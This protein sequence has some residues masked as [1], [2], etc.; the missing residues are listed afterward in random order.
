M[1]REWFEDKRCLDIGCNA[2]VV[3]FDIARTFFPSYILGID[4]DPSLIEKAHAGIHIQDN[5]IKKKL[6]TLLARF[7]ISCRQ[8]KDIPVPTFPRNIDFVCGNFLDEGI[9]LETIEE[10]EKVTDPKIDCKLNSSDESINVT[11]NTGKDTPKG[12][13]LK[14][15]D[16][17]LCLSTTKWIHL[18]WGD[19]GIYQLFRKVHSLLVDGGLL[20]LEPQTW[21]TYKKKSHMTKET[22]KNY[23]SIQFK[24]DSFIEFLT[25]QLS[26][27]LLNTLC[28]PSNMV[29]SESFS[30]R[31]IYIL[32]KKT[33]CTN[34]SIVGSAQQELKSSN[35]QD[36]KTDITQN[37]TVSTFNE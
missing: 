27:V 32:Q 9:L 5:M 34:E 17:V 16:V 29:L 25:N 35:C 37:I 24:P 36:S 20:I 33:F 8:R 22:L 10:E 6:N 15:F 19:K 26:F 7:P 12:N 4:I 11:H 23:K 21:K 18:N 13:P 1:S 31:K 2:G 30:S 14:L 3:S 28:L